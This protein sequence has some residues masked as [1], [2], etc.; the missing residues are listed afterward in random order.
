V[1][2]R[3]AG[4]AAESAILATG[5]LHDRLDVIP[6][7]AVTGP[8]HAERLP[9]DDTMVVTL[10]V[11]DLREIVRVAV[12]EALTT[13]GRHDLLGLKQVGER[14]RIGREAVVAAAKRGEIALSQGLAG[15]L[16][17]PLDPLRLPLHWIRARAL[18]VLS[19]VAI[20]YC[21]WRAFE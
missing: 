17:Q 18:S 21:V 11:Q 13:K 6:P 10:R 5:K 3:Q 19:L 8:M 20:A 16:I 14:Y 1:V 15:S 12:A 4:R 2:A 7:A 9:A